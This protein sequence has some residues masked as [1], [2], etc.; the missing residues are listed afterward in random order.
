[1]KSVAFSGSYKDLS[2]TPILG[3]AA[4]KDVAASGNASTTQVVM[5][6]D[7]RLTDARKAS[8]VSAW[9]KAA[10]KPYYT[11]SEVGAAAANHTH[12]NY[13]LSTHEVV[14]SSE[15]TNQSVGD[16]WIKRIN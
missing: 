16:Y 4:A 14:F 3:T 6:N 15:P 5:G 12:S 1:M 10:S 9:A 8:D 13:M 7:T 2:D 11:A